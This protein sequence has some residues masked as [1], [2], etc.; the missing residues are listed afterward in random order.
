M[1]KLSALL[2]GILLLSGCGGGGDYEEGKRVCEVNKMLDMDGVEIILTAT[3]SE[4]EVKKMTFDFTMD[5]N[6]LLEE[7]AFS[8]NFDDMSDEDKAT[9]KDMMAEQMETSIADE[10][11]SDSEAVTAESDLD[12][13]NLIIKLEID[14]EK[15]DGGMQKMS[16]DEF[17]EM[18]ES[19]LKGTCK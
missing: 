13:S 8:I 18:V 15:V 9:F 6:A 1:K 11:G 3:G 4:E 7:T 14:G 12:G 10:F 17:V 2:E 5:M 19:D 16:M